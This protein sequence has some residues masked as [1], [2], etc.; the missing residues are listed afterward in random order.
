VLILPVAA[1]V[2]LVEERWRGGGRWF[3]VGFLAFLFLI[4]W[5]IYFRA[6]DPAVALFFSA[7]ILITVVLYWV[8]W[9]ALRPPRTPVDSVR[10]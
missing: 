7:P 1:I 9:W 3:V 10:A 5:S 8:R 2:L 6:A 4:L